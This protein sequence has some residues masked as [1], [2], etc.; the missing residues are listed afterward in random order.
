MYLWHLVVQYLS[1]TYAFAVPDATFRLFYTLDLLRAPVSNR[2]A[3][4]PRAFGSAC[5]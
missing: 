4:S 1:S 5:S 2:L 3:R